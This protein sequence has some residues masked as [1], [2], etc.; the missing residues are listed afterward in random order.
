MQTIYPAL[1]LNSVDSF[2]PK[3]GKELQQ[4][5][6]N[7]MLLALLLISIYIA[8]RFDRYYALGSVIAL[9]HDVLITLGLLS[10]L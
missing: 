4:S 9:I 6:R 1:K 7:A 10:V 3:L 8:L 5:A 2:G